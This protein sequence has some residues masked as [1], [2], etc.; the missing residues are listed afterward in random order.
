MTP[1]ETRSLLVAAPRRIS[2]LA[3]VSPL[4]FESEVARLSSAQAGVRRRLEFRYGAAAPDLSELRAEL[5]QA[6]IQLERSNEWALAER[7]T[8]LLLEAQLAE[9]RD[10]AVFTHLACKR[11]Q[12]SPDPLVSRESLLGESDALA[13]AWCEQSPPLTHGLTESATVIS[14]DEADSRS[15]V[16]RMRHAI[17]EA[18]LAVRVVCSRQLVP[19]AAV[20]D[21]FVQVAAGRRIS[22]V[23]VER[24]VRHEL[25][26]HVRP[27]QRAQRSAFVLGVIGTA[28]GSDTQEGFALLLERRSGFLG[29]ARALELALRHRAGRLAHSGVPFEQALEQL[30]DGAHPTEVVV[31][32]V[33]RAFRGG[34]LGREVAYVPA[35]LEV[36]RAFAEDPTI[37]ERLASGRLSLSAARALRA[38]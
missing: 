8:E 24:T 9:A 7:A 37:E 3:T 27:M 16:S 6:A 19:L 36:E 38:E 12:H 33:A 28:R 15:L 35:L 17:G 2:L 11:Y 10:S 31:R 34:G 22:T 4:N 18:R 25:D 26:G 30:D 29:G 5:E 20:G 32:A 14:D 1:R 23:D 13:R 21:G